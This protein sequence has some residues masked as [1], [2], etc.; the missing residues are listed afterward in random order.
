MRVLALSQALPLG[1]LR[2]LALDALPPVRPAP[3][4]A[5][6]HSAALDGSPASAE[7]GVGATLA[8]AMSGAA[9]VYAKS[10]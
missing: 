2:R 7:R 1:S 9:G 5:M 10:A 4:S 3:G 8:Q 6:L